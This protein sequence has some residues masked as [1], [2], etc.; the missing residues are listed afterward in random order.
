MLLIFAKFRLDELFIE[1]PAVYQNVVE[2]VADASVTETRNVLEAQA[3]QRNNDASLHIF[4]DSSICVCVCG[5][6]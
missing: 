2:T 6:Q 4:A 1:K 3:N 5:Q